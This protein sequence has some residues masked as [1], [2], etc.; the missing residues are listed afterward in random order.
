M[1]FSFIEDTD[2][3]TKVETDYA[4]EE[5]TRKE[6]TQKL[7]EDSISAMTEKNAQLLDEKKKIQKT[8]RDFD[9]LD[10][11]AAK[12]ALKFLENNEDAQ[13]IKD[14]KIEELLDRRTSTLRTDHEAVVEDL[15]TNLIEEKESKKKYKGLY[16]S[17]LL[18]DALTSAAI[19]AKVLPSAI[20]DVLLN[21]KNI[22]SVADDGTIEA[23]DKDGKIRKT[24]DGKVLDTSIWLN[25]RKTTSVHW[26]GMSEGGNLTPGADANDYAAALANAATKGDTAA[27]RR[28]RKKKK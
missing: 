13:L 16:Q 24:D 9:G 17:K 20:A 12:E 8:L 2:L 14:G 6:E 27:F 1:D 5:A 22:F 15:S 21:G 11:E 7:V 19:V 10:A 23:R 4:T 3:R 18:D 28:L 26:W 25:D